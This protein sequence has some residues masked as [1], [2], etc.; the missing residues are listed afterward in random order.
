MSEY[1]HS[2]SLDLEKCKGCTH[3]L[4]RCPTEAI[5]IRDGHAVI[6]PARCIDCGECIR[7]CPH[8]AKKAIY[9]KF[10]SLPKDK[11][12]IALPAPTFYGQFE[13]LDDIDYLLQGLLDLGFDDVF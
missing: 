2:V 8:K 1:K 5:R 9:D 6:D 10:S 4:R 11:Y 7:L 3:C 13:N 12:L